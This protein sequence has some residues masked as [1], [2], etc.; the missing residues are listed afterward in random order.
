[1]YLDDGYYLSVYVCADPLENIADAFIRHDHNISLWFKTDSQVH[2]VHHWELERLSGWKHHSRPFIDREH[3][4]SF[5]NSLIGRYGLTFDRLEGVWGCPSLDRGAVY[6]YESEYAGLT[7][8]SLCHLFS[9]LLIDSAQFYRG[10]TIAL[11]VDGAPDTVIDRRE[12]WF[13]G[14]VVQDGRL[15]VFEIES[16]GPLWREAV[17]SYH[18]E[19]GSLMAIASAST[20]AATIDSPAV[21]Y[22]GPESRKN[23]RLVFR[24]LHAHASEILEQR[25]HAADFTG[26]DPR[27]SYQE[28]LASLVMKNVQRL[29]MEVVERTISKILRQFD[30]DPRGASLA[31]AGG[32]ALNC[33]SNSFLMQRF[34]FSGFTSL[35]AVNDGGQAIGIGLFAFYRAAQGAPFHFR[36]DD[37]YVGDSGGTI[38][39]WCTHPSYA[40]Y[41]ASVEELS[42]AQAVDDL[43]Q[44][45]IVWFA[46]RAELG[47]RALG[48][49]SILGDPRSEETKEI[50]NAKK[51]RQWW[52]PVAP[53]VLE[54]HVAEWFAEGHRSPYMLETFQIRPEK[55]ALIPAVAHLDGSARIQTVATTDNATLHTL[56]EAFHIRTGIPVLCNTS[57]N[58][59][60]EPIINTVE[61]ALN[62]AL[63]MQFPV[64]YINGKRI[65]LKRSEHFQD[66]GP[67]TRR[68]Q[69]FLMSD[70][71]AV[72]W[73][74]QLNPHQLSPRTLKIYAEYPDLRAHYDITLSHDAEEV[75]ALASKRKAKNFHD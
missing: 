23:A 63:R 50:L 18:L 26:L 7:F 60:G 42:P 66:T 46:G 27:F 22:Y 2:L 62:F 54:A 32:Y 17:W 55:L 20:C 58:D 74:S 41:I 40:P 19:E 56:L 69:E 1:M 34:G 45:P 57:L 5:I 47:P 73:Q 43:I 3:A 48:N 68:G 33:P 15:S 9:C 29:S 6:P 53:L 36:L 61:E 21:E 16:P 13:S 64:A 44:H 4:I 24:S 38:T 25:R 75:A 14:A 51:K 49:R 67:A 8:H 70:D 10:T 35:P 30:I 28:N 39:D 37:P 59:K 31:L 65:S 72:R 71:A 12:H 11:A 52:R